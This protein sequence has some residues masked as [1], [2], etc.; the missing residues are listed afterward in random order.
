[1]AGDAQECACRVAPAVAPAPRSGHVGHRPGAIDLQ[2][3][4]LLHPLL[5]AGDR[6]RKGALLA[7]RCTRCCTRSSERAFGPRGKPRKRPRCTR[8][9]TRSSERAGSCRRSDIV[10]RPLHPLLHPLLGAGFRLGGKELG[11]LVAPAVAPAPRS[12]SSSVRTPS[13]SPGL[14][15]LLHPLLGAGED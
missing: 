4:P 2:L 9:C 5:G 12:G 6:P 10:D 8:C 13:R 14:H 1:M 3:H 15:P 7:A 11:Q